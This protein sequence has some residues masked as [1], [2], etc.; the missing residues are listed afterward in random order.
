MGMLD[1][2]ARWNT[3][4]SGPPNT[5]I[6][7]LSCVEPVMEHSNLYL[8]YYKIRIWVT[9]FANYFGDEVYFSRKNKSEVCVKQ[10]DFVLDY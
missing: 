4:L 5:F 3:F 6:F 8:I 10:D 9:I 2:E 1:W 7:F